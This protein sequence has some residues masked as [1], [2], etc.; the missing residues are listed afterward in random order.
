MTIDKLYLWAQTLPAKEQIMQSRKLAKTLKGLKKS[1]YVS[2]SVR[3]EIRNNLI[4]RMRNKEELFP[5]M[6]GYDNSVIPQVENAILAGQ[7]IIFLGERGQG[8]SRLI[9]YLVGLLDESIPYVQDC[10]IHD[11]PY[12]PI[13]SS[14]KDKS[15]Q[16][17]ESLP[18]SWLS[19]EDRYSE[20]L[21]TPDISVADLI[22]EIDPIKV[23][24]GRY[25][26][27]EL[28]IHYGLIPRTNRGIFAIN[29]LPDLSERI[30]VSLF[31]LMEERDIQIKG[32]RIRL[33]IDVYLIASANPEDYTNRGRIITPL[34]DRYGSQIRTHYPVHTDQEVAIMEQEMHVF[35]DLS[36][37]LI[38]PKFMKDII[39]EVT[40]SARDSGDIN[41]RSGVSVRVSIANYESVLSSAYKR[42][43]KLDEDLAS[44]RISDLSAL[45]PSTIGKIE[46]EA[47]DEGQDIKI[48]ED[49][50]K[51]S[52]LRVFNE[53]FKTDEELDELVSQFEEGFTF[54][55]SHS[56][57]SSIYLNELKRIKPFEDAISKFAESS[58][59][60]TQASCIE[61][62]LEGLHLRRRL[63]KDQLNN[64]V[65][66][67]I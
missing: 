21:A 36:D 22:G 37:K 6:V 60:A 62:L 55:A 61:F 5:G 56:H 15:N 14:C 46:L 29:E 41:Q 30:Q 50:I 10:E 17:G 35:P 18:I 8:K 28:T 40:M 1:G 58:T 39:A 3:D 67:K 65:K 32:Y 59:P 23:A 31:N 64:G 66:Y 51:K 9:R 25:L 47:L 2:V 27:D 53:Y 7:D 57:P 52:V 49:L 16:Y 54:E 26:S 34:K 24:E 11:D 43:I 45:I 42:S 44:P 20:K 63:N 12:N 48:M 38:V 33:P 4:T 13:C 19:R